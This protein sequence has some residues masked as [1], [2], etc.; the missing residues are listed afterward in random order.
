VREG[1][2]RDLT[3]K[4]KRAQH[5][6]R[7]QAVASCGDEVV[8]HERIEDENDA[9]DDATHRT[10]YYTPTEFQNAQNVEQRPKKSRQPDRELRGAE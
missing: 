9:R 4:R 7:R 8:E 2:T 6:T 3:G 5:K 1:H 10:A